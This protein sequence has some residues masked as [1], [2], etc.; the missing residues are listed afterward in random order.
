[1]VDVVDLVTSEEEEEH[2]E[3]QIVL[4]ALRRA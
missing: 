1:M 3:E 4:N 2:K